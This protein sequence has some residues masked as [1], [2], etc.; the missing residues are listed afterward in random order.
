MLCFIY[1]GCASFPGTQRSLHAHAFC[2]HKKILNHASLAEVESVKLSP[3][4]FLSGKVNP[5]QMD[6]VTYN[7]AASTV[8]INDEYLRICCNYQA[9][10]YNLRISSQGKKKKAFS[11]TFAT[12]SSKSLIIRPKL[13]AIIFSIVYEETM[14]CSQHS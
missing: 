1:F 13:C 9:T 6:R 7:S 8:S 3:P 2:P 10:F 5:H 14:T 12:C 4:A 11:R